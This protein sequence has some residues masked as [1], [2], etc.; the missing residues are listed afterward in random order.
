MFTAKFIADHACRLSCTNGYLRFSAPTKKQLPSEDCSK[1]QSYSTAAPGDYPM[2]ARVQVRAPRQCLPYIRTQYRFRQPSV[3]RYSTTFHNSRTALKTDSVAIRSTSSKRS[4]VQSI[5]DTKRNIHLFG[6]QD[7]GKDEARNARP[8]QKKVE[9]VAHKQT[10]HLNGQ[11]LEN[12]DLQED[13]I[14][15]A[16]NEET[17]EP[18]LSEKKTNKSRS[19]GQDGYFQHGD[20]QETSQSQEP[21]WQTSTTSAID[22]KNNSAMSL[23]EALMTLEQPGTEMS[24]PNPNTAPKQAKRISRAK[25]STTAMTDGVL[26]TDFRIICK[27]L[28]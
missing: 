25:D 26:A 19:T 24:T 3:R 27:P 4:L 7:D 10:S 13:S 23:K 21:R 2:L 17:L 5:E 9:Q 12:G 1:A 20:H 16:F 18:T 8:G 28:F 14:W 11:G 6:E 22:P 15:S